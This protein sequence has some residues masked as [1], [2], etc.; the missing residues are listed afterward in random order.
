[1]K[2]LNE[3]KTKLKNINYKVGF[4][5]LN[6]SYEKEFGHELMKMKLR[7]IYDIRIKPN[8]FYIT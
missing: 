1:M 6:P 8:N 3:I 7:I 2:M 4:I 5:T